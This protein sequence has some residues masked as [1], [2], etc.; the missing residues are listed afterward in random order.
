MRLIDADGQR[1]VLFACRDMTEQVRIRDALQ[2]RNAEMEQ[3][4]YTVSHD[5]KSP[6]VTIKGFLG[7]VREGLD[8]GEHELVRTDLARIASAADRMTT[9]LDDLLDLSRV[10]RAV[11]L[12]GPVS[13]RAVVA[14]AVEAV[15]GSL[16]EHHVAVEIADGL[17][18][19]WGDRGRLT[20]VV[21]NLVE[22]A[23]KYMGAQPAP[24][25]E[26]GAVVDPERTRLFV[27]DNGI[28]IAA[29]HHDRVFGLF[30]KLDPRAEG[31]GVGLSLV[32][33]IV[34]FHGGS[35]W[36]ESEGEG[37]GSTFW[38]ALPRGPVR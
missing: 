12:Q 18:E 17:P 32:R 36:V 16:R 8:A 25:I 33:R 38:V 19:V 13:L 37:R 35:T 4:V 14:D 5:L 29:R 11:D 21:Q 26:I 22:N 24:R 23:A 6:L 28:G 10:G 20:Q 2:A 3:F 7:S 31:T 15:F 30:E 9:L 34:E 1:G 27:R